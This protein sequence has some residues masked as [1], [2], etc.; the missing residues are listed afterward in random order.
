MTRAIRRDTVPAES[1]R[2]ETVEGNRYFP[3]DAV[4]RELLRASDTYSICPWKGTASY[5]KGVRV[6]D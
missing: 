2:C 6:E 3:P 4:R 5:S 1:D